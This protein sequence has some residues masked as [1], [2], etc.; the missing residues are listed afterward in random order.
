MVNLGVA[1]TKLDTTSNANAQTELESAITTFDDAVLDKTG[2]FGPAGDVSSAVAAGAFTPNGTAVTRSATTFSSVSGTAAFGGTASL[3]ATLTSQA[4]SQPLSGAIVNF[5]LDGA[6]VG[7]TTT[8]SSGVA[9][10]TDVPTSD[11]VGT[12]SAGIVASYSG[13]FGLDA[14]SASGDLTV[15]PAATS[16]SAVSGTATFGGTASLTAT[17]TS[18]VTSQGISGATVSF[19]LDGTSVGTATTNSS[20]VATLDRRHHHGQRR[21]RHGWRGRQLR[22]NTELRRR[23]ECHRQPGR[24]PGSHDLGQRLGHGHV[25]RHRHAH[26]DPHL[27]GHQCGYR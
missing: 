11:A 3:T 12:D 7:T 16:L 10:L 13:A 8:N 14:S 24:Q 2:V 22:G 1:A 25:R 4:T 19:T 9:T 17:L 6:Y 18:Q 15:A 27:I 5:T 23:L 21:Y 26:G 20:G